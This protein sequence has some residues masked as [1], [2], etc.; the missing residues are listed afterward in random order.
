MSPRL[1]VSQGP[2]RETTLGISFRVYLIQEFGYT[3]NGRIKM[4]N[5][6]LGGNPEVI[7]SKKCLP[8]LGLKR[9][10]EEVVLPESESWANGQ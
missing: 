8:P 9:Y 6:R 3:G 10:R 5:R 7:K 4:S 1:I 2:A